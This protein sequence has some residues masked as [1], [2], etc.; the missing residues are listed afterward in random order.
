MKASRILI[1]GL[2]LGSGLA[3]QACSTVT[4]HHSIA[5]SQVAKG[6]LEYA[7]G[8]TAPEIMTYDPYTHVETH[9]L[10]APKGAALT[11]QDRAANR[12]TAVS[13]EHVGEAGYPLCSSDGHDRD[14]ASTR[15]VGPNPVI[16]GTVAG[17]VVGAAVTKSSKGA[18]AG[19]AI[20]AT[21]GSTLSNSG[22]SN[23]IS[24]GAATGAIIGSATGGKDAAAAGA[25][26]GA[27]LGLD[28]KGKSGSDK[29]EG[30]RDH[31]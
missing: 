2:A 22:D 25:V 23:A 17:A 6:C 31:K 20:G 24:L 13:A 8:S 26:A 7:E 9:V 21:M 5:A 19:A 15:S 1:A 18:E 14:Y 16:V 3:L 4:S 27:L 10:E 29:D 12:V 11:V 28:A 30:G